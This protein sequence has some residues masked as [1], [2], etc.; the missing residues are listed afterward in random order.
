M[1]QSFRSRL[2][3]SNLII[4]L[5]GLLVVVVVFTQVLSQRT[6]DVKKS[7]REAQAQLLATQIH[8]LFLNPR[9]KPD[10]PCRLAEVASPLLNASRIILVRHTG[11]AYFDS[12]IRGNQPCAHGSYTPVDRSALANQESAIRQLYKN[13]SVY[14]F[15]AP[16]QGTDHRNAGAVVL[17]A[18][19]SDVRPSFQ[20]LESVFLVVL[21]TALLVWLF[22]GLYFTVSISRPL[23]RVTA[24]TRRMAR[25]D[26]DVR[27]P[28]QGNGEIAHLARSFNEMAEQVQRSNR[29]L[30][31]FV[32]N[33]S[34]DLRT[35][36]T[37]ITGFSQ[38]LLDG[39]AQPED[40]SESADVIHEESLKMQRMVDDLLQLTRL[41]SGLLHFQTT[42]VDTHA[43]VQSVVERV[44]R[45]HI[46][47]PGAELRNQISPGIPPVA[48]DREQMERALRNLVE[49]A[50]QYTP[51]DG[52]VTVRGAIIGRGWVEL[53]VADTGMGIPQ[54]DL[55]R[56]FER[57]YRSDKSRE[58]AHGHSGLG[59]AIAREIVE[60]HG[61]QI[62]VESEPGRGTTFS[63]TVP[64]MPRES[65]DDEP[66]TESAR[67]ALQT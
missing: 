54:T 24:A 20:S 45:A 13:S 47:A 40:V 33:V 48:I 32:A 41:E 38:A 57:F 35:P 56:V 52:S 21:G 62:R 46:D 16:I 44:R 49:N 29:V 4:T 42:P 1:L 59:L 15:Q 55:P 36:L 25:G 12:N 37:M 19:V 39:T 63:F 43:F 14:A 5:F 11:A 3:I 34:H 65:L 6:I 22:I 58:R 53:S 31:D 28:G 7:D 27:V 66:Y 60:G 51:S 30:K 26:Y 61:G 9:V 18:R 64:Q 2:V 17:V 50:L 8:A 10:E 23:L 67:K